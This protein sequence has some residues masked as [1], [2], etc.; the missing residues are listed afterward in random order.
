VHLKAVKDFCKTKEPLKSGSFAQSER[1]VSDHW[2]ESTSIA[3]KTM[4]LPTWPTTF[5]IAML[6]G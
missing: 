1:C 6:A 3:F 2:C 4:L 5:R